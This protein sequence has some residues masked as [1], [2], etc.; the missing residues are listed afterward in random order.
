MRLKNRRATMQS[1]LITST[2][3]RR[4]G[5][6]FDDKSTA[7]KRLFFWLFSAVPLCSRHA[8]RLAIHL[9]HAARRQFG[10]ILSH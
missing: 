9:Q 7:D 3:F 1:A 5:L 8:H 6:P 4:L 10:E 2:K